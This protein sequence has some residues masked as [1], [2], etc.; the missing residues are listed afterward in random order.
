MGH[1][2]VT[3]AVAAHPRS[4]AYWCDAQ[5]QRLGTMFLYQAI[6]LTNEFGY[7]IPQG[8]F[9]GG[10]APLCL[11]NRCR[12]MLANFIRLP[13]RGDQLF[14]FIQYSLTLAWCQFLLVTF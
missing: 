12:A 9:N 10:K 4:K 14:Q 3:I 11:I 7:G 1:I 6:Q 5:R 13:G 2:R 8:L